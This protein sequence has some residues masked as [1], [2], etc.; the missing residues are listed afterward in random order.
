[1]IKDSAEIAH[2]TKPDVARNL[3]KHLTASYGNWIEFR[4]TAG[5][6]RCP[7][8]EHTK[9]LIPLFKAFANGYL[10]AQPGIQT[11]AV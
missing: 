3:H 7:I 6:I 4:V 8:N 11:L 5:S 9:P 2:T 1:M 10:V